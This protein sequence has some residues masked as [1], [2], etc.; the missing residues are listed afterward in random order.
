MQIKKE[1]PPP[2]ARRGATHRRPKP[3]ETSSKSV[4][5]NNTWGDGARS[6]ARGEQAPKQHLAL[7]MACQMHRRTAENITQNT[8][9]SS[10]R[11]GALA[12]R[13]ASASANPHSCL[14]KRL[15]DLDHFVKRG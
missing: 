10:R 8:L 14:K 2:K 5:L 3:V 13:D 6:H 1:P 12:C 7:A 11:Y 9:H 4:C 15:A